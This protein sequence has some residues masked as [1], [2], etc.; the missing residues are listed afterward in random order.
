MTQAIGQLISLKEWQAQ[1]FAG[2]GPTLCTIRRWCQD[3]H[4]PAKKIGNQWY[5]DL[6]AETQLASNGQTPWPATDITHTTPQI[7][8]EQ[9]NTH[10]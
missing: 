1:R 2:K 7:D 4:L 6:E 10:A 9:E 5:I 8:T 3:G